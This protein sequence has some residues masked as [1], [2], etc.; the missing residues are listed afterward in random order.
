MLLNHC[1]HRVMMMMMSVS[2]SALL[3][4]IAWP[5]DCYC[6][7]CFI[8]HLQHAIWEEWLHCP[9]VSFLHECIPVHTGGEGRAVAMKHNLRGLKKDFCSTFTSRTCS[10]SSVTCS[11]PKSI[12]T[13]QSNKIPMTFKRLET[14]AWR[15]TDLSYFFKR[16]KCKSQMQ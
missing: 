16:R 4:Y 1:Q 3:S 6:H 14:T 11:A 5:R 12:L 13:Q 2:F 7:A 8:S 10:A 9:P 15:S